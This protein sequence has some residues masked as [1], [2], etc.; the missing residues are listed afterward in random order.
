MVV[1]LEDRCDGDGGDHTRRAEDDRIVSTDGTLCI[2]SHTMLAK[3]ILP[4]PEIVGE[5][6]E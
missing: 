4:R 5:R 1:A 2:A 6:C 3:K